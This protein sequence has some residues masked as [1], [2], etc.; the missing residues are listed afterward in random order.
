MGKYRPRVV[1]AVLRSRLESAGAV[2]V[3]G[4][5]GCGKTMTASQQARTIVEVDNDP[6]VRQ[7]LAADQDALFLDEPPI[8]FDEWQAEPG[9]W[10]V[11]R[12]QVDKRSARG[13]CILSG[14]ATP[15]DDAKRHSGIGRFSHVRMYPMTGWERGIYPGGVSLGGLCAGA[16]I[17]SQRVTPRS[18]PQL[19][20]DALHGGWPITYDAPTETAVDLAQDYVS[21]LCEYDIPDL[22][23]TRRRNPGAVR[24]LLSSIAR[25][26][27][28]AP[29]LKTLLGDVAAKDESVSREKISRWLD[30]LQRMFVLERV[31]AWSPALRSKARLRSG[32]V[33]HLAD[34]SLVGV[35]L[36]ANVNNLRADPETAGLV[37]ESYVYQQVAAFAAALRADVLHYR[38]SNGYEFDQ[39]LS[40]PDGSWAGIEVKLGAGNIQ[41]GIDSLLNTTSQINTKGLG[42]PR[43]LILLVGG[44][45]TAYRDP[46]GVSVVPIQALEP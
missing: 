7:L 18:V 44:S 11:I 34:T 32:D 45:E 46:S 29:T 33:F 9:L 14:S 21:R 31:P 1:D 6:R 39:V 41:A 16:Q 35:L 38:D 12:R 4:P 15:A 20:D 25:N 30:A 2:I 13:L 17:S 22:A 28:Q 40:L 42:W 24:A 10:N 8:L 37:F 43:A 36:G 19:L 5:R 27:S 26:V 23:G 3:E